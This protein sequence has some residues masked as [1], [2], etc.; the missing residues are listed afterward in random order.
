MSTEKPKFVYVTLIKTT[1]EKL[2]TALTDPEFMR[3]YWPGVQLESDWKTGSQW[4]MRRPDG[5][6]TDE[7]TVIKSEP[8]RLLSYTFHHLHE[9][10]K[11]EKPSRVTFEIES[12]GG[13]SDLQGPAVKLTVVHDEFAQDSTVLP[14]ISG[15]W[16]V[17]LSGLKTLLETG[18]SLE[19]TKKSCQ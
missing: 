15:G 16:P 9:A 12:L 1:P 8:P 11:H 7:G 2:W 17:I 3:Q 10:S 6:I 4:K 18:H 19:L 13:K 14:K 5:S